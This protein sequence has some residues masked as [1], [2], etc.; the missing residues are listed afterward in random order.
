MLKEFVYVFFLN[1]HVQLASTGIPGHSG[2][3]AACKDVDNVILNNTAPFLDVIKVNP[4][5][6][7]GCFSIKCGIM[8]VVIGTGVIENDPLAGARRKDDREARSLLFNN[9]NCVCPDAFGVEIF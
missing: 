8:E 9:G 2:R 1:A 4:V 7:A 6:M 3:T 5:H